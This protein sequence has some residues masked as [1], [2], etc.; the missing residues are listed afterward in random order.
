MR[1]II[2]I[3]VIH[4]VADFVFQNDKMA[5]NKSK[6]LYWLSIHVLVYTVVLF[7]G[8]F[9]AFRMFS[10]GMVAIYALANGVLH[11]ITDFFTSKLTSRLAQRESKHWF[12]VAVG[13]DQLVHYVCLLTTYQF[14]LI[15][16]LA[17]LARTS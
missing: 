1:Y 4:F 13:F 10:P 6:S 16:Y 9:F 12:F 8:S 5:L 11:F 2:S 3:L 14:L 7:A 17:H 15:E